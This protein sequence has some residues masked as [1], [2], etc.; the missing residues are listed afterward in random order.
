MPSTA[1][2]PVTHAMSIEIP[3]RENLDDNSAFHRL[4]DLAG[5]HVAKSV[6]LDAA[7]AATLNMFTVTGTVIIEHI[8]GYCTEATDSTT[9]QDFKWELDDGA[10]QSDISGEVNA[11]GA[12]VGAILMKT[13]TAAGATEFVNPTAGVVTDAGSKALFEP[14]LLT[15]KT[16]DVTTYIRASY[17]G[18]ATAD[19]DWTFEIHYSSIGEDAKVSAV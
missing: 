10:A 17:T 13:A 15:Q 3:S 11:S 14:F 19:T 4:N 8:F 18:D 1:S 9:I 16:G 7:G 5:V 6:T 2:G 12:V